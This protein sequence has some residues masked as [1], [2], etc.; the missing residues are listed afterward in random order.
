M[1]WRGNKAG[2]N[3]G[4]RFPRLRP[5]VQDR[6]AAA[7]LESALVAPIYVFTTICLFEIAACF[8]WQGVLDV[9]VKMAARQVQIGCAQQTY[10]SA[11]GF[12]NN[13]ICP[14]LYGL[15]S[16]SNVLVDV[17]SVSDFG[18]GFSIPAGSNVSQGNFSYDGNS[19][20]DQQMVVRAIYMAPVFLPTWIPDVV[21]FKGRNAFPLISV[22]AF[23]NEPFS[24]SPPVA[25]CT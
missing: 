13:G 21:R 7:A 24:T 15:M 23:F 2:K 3:S 12:V 17:R 4:R 1:I 14:K 8:F 5:L 11:T 25:S 9:G 18:A 10:G 22:S 20:P 16:C 6:R 19:G